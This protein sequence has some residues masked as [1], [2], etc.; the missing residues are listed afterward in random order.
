[1]GI[2][3]GMGMGMGWRRALCRSI[4][5]AAATP[6][7]RS[8]APTMPA[9]HRQHLL[10]QGQ[11]PSHACS[12]VPHQAAVGAAGREHQDEEDRWRER[13]HCT[14]VHNLCTTKCIIWLEIRRCI[15]GMH[16]EWAMQNVICSMRMH[17]DSWSQPKIRIYKTK[18]G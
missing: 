18:L 16:F 15:E 12:L 14:S 9:P 11:Q 1:M 3:M 17:Y 2:G 5:R 10:L 8:T 6:R 13:G 7:R 4:Q